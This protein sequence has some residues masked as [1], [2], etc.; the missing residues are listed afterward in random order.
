MNTQTKKSDKKNSH[1]GFV[2]SQRG[3]PGGFGRDVCE[4]DGP[5]GF[6]R[7]VCER[8]GPGGFGR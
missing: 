8:G 3:G 6:G 5:G 4:R 7:D 1:N 2:W